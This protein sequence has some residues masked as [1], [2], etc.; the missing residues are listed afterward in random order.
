MG[1]QA[2]AGGAVSGFVTGYSLGTQ[3]LGG[4]GLRSVGSGLV[5]AVVG[6]VAA[7]RAAIAASGAAAR[8][9]RQ[10]K[11]AAYTLGTVL[12]AASLVLAGMSGALFPKK[13]DKDLEQ[14]VLHAEHPIKVTVGNE[15]AKELQKLG[16]NVSAGQY[17]VNVSGNHSFVLGGQ[18]V[19][20]EKAQQ[21]LGKL[22][23]RDP[24]RVSVLPGQLGLIELHGDAARAAGQAA[25]IG[26]VSALSILEHVADGKASG[27]FMADGKSGQLNA[28]QVAKINDAFDN[29]RV[30]G[31]YARVSGKL[32]IGTPQ[33]FADY[34]NVLAFAQGAPYH[35]TLEEV[36]GHTP[37]EIFNMSA[38]RIAGND[39]FQQGG[40]SAV[41]LMKASLVAKG[42][43]LAGIS[44]NISA[45]RNNANLTN[46][47]KQREVVNYLVQVDY[48][49][50]HDSVLLADSLTGFKDALWN[51]RSAYL[52]ALGVGSRAAL[53]SRSTSDLVNLS[54]K[55]GILQQWDSEQGN[56]S[57][58]KLQE[59]QELGRANDIAVTGLTASQLEALLP[60]DALVDYLEGHGVA[61]P[62]NQKAN[63]AYL[64]QQVDGLISAKYLQGFRD[65]ASRLGL[66]SPASLD[67][68]VGKVWE[69]NNASD[70]TAYN[71][72]FSDA[73][74][75]RN[76]ILY[77]TER[78]ASYFVGLVDNAQ[79]SRE[80]GAWE[81]A[82]R[83]IDSL[84]QA[85]LLPNYE[86][87][88]WQ[89][90]K[91]DNGTNTS[92]LRDIANEKY[93][94]NRTLSNSTV[95]YIIDFANAETDWTVRVYNTTGNTSY[96]VRGW[97]VDG[98]FVRAD[99]GF[100]INDR[101]FSALS[102]I[103]GRNE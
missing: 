59:L 77:L 68:L 34:V 5:G 25:G 101:E 13:T 56:A 91:F 83:S 32:N 46:E 69:W 51:T 103:L 64:G 39:T 66:D 3:F 28:S 27:A 22:Y 62:E 100:V 23:H 79:A 86:S 98:Q 75:A 10:I 35:F 61:V 90:V 49:L 41:D 7:N 73:V 102:D 4:P 65:F 84:V 38:G 67:D 40:W 16:V 21:V 76:E 24:A 57:T 99:K 71:Q 36:F 1:R 19:P 74:Q 31:S 50:G 70:R 82:Q 14:V 8:A 94:A 53:D 97:M 17:E 33:D 30:D 9:A 42:A 96:L 72:G 95:D 60:A 52:N 20:A 58:Y 63:R 92:A 44:T 6:A 85:R 18:F 80:L 12:P 48:Q 88:P 78:N 81:Q 55:T 47:Q 87:N 15:T 89:S 26:N 43:D 45:I 2:A 37:S 54:Y 93:S 29:G 11:A